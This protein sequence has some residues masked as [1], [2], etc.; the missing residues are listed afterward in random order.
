MGEKGPDLG[1]A[2]A[3]TVGFRWAPLVPLVL[4]AS[5]GI[6]VDRYVEPWG[7]ATWAALA[8]GAGAAALLATGRD[9]AANLAVVRGL[10]RP[11]WRLAPSP[12]VR[13]RARRPEL[14][15]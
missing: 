7:T 15:G 13:S 1:D 5:L 2:S 4:A 3:R 8:L 11:G 14:G 12:L 6:V 10:R 9:L